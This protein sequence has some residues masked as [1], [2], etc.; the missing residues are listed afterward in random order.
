MFRSLQQ[1]VQSAVDKVG[2]QVS[3]FGPPVL[4]ALFVLVVTFIIARIVR[5]ALMRSF[6]GVAID[7]FLC[8]SGV[9]SMLGL[10]GRI[11]ASRLVTY[12]AYWAIVMVGCLTALNV[13]GTR[14]TNDIVSAAGSLLPLSVGAIAVVIAGVWVGQYVGRTALVWT[15]E[16]GL[17]S[18]RRWSTGVRALIILM[19]LVIASDVLNFAERVFFAAFLIVSGG[20]VLALSIAFG[21]GSG[22]AVESYFAKRREQSNEERRESVWQHL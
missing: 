11:R 3:T 22:K 20:V 4:A 7:R 18:P 1:I 5:W 10:G 15:H 19:S 16:E 12:T 6:R 13:F 2:E 17:P 9:A 21:L 14:T 8:E